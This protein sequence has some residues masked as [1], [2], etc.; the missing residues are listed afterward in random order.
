MKVF[1]ARAY[2]SVLQPIR[3]LVYTDS[4]IGCN[5]QAVGDLCQG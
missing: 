3:S 2:S 1:W 5:L 4:A